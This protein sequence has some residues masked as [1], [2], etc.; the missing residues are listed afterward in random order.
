MGSLFITIYMSQMW[1]NYSSVC[2]LSAAVAQGK[3]RLKGADRELSTRIIFEPTVQEPPVFFFFFLNSVSPCYL[4]TSAVSQ[5]QEE[6]LTKKYDCSLSKDKREKSR[7]ECF[8]LRARI[9]L[10]HFL[11]SLL[12]VTVSQLINSEPS[13]TQ[14]LRE[15]RGLGMLQ[16]MDDK[17]SILKYSLC[18]AICK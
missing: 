15:E 10:Y 4:S 2:L 11:A 12:Q 14:H 1:P 8:T 13:E 3:K 7:A 17:F 9:L 6:I 16:D 18:L 5:C